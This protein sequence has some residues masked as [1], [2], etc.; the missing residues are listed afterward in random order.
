MGVDSQEQMAALIPAQ[1]LAPAHIRQ[2]GQ[3]ARATALGR[4]RGNAGAVEGFVRAPL[5]YRERHE[6]QQTHHQ[7]CL[8]L[9]HLAGELIRAGTVG[10]AARTGRR[11]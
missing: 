2:A 4:P 3:P 1:P 8:L 10:K 11:A 5:G 7:R 6:V 9:A